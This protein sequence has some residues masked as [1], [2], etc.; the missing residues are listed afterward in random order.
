[1]SLAA[2]ILAAG[3][4]TRM[5][6]DKVKVIHDVAGKALVTYVIEAV[7]GAGILDV[8]LVIGYQGDSVK[9]V[10]SEECAHSYA[11]ISYVEQSEQKGTGHAV[12]VCRDA[13]E[14]KM[15]GD[16]IVL[17]GDCPLVRSET[18]SHVIE[19]H[20]QTGAGGTILTAIMEEPAHYG[21]ILRDKD[22]SVLGIREARDCSEEQLKIT[23]INT[24]VYVFRTGLLFECLDLLSTDNA[25]GEYYLTDV[26]EIMRSKGFPISGYCTPHSDEVVGVNSPQDLAHVCE[27]I[28]S[29]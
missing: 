4:G 15:D 8:C 29:Q 16:V 7:V 13:F 24:G 5:K 17:A 12:M 1:M 2:I 10:V 20:H 3:K 25:Q 19:L 14:S 28:A 27:L 6:S 18:I 22:G 26:L 11:E 9:A 21:R 23:E